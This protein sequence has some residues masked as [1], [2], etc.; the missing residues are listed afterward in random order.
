MTT[1]SATPSRQASWLELFFDLV[2]VA[3]IAQLALLLREHADW[4]HIGIF[5]IVYF[6]VWSTWTSFTFY[7]NV[8][9]DKAHVR[10]MILGMAAMGVMAAAIPHVTDQRT[11]AFIVTYVLARMVTGQI[12]NRKGA[13]VTAWPAAQVGFGVAPWVWSIWTPAPWTYLLWAAGMALD[14]GFSIW[15]GRRPQGMMTQ[16]SLAYAKRAER[17]RRG[18]VEVPQHPYEAAIDAKHLG[19]RIGLFMIIVLGEAIVQVVDVTAEEHWHAYL[20]VAAGA[21]FGIAVCLWL[22]TF[23]YGVLAVPHVSE[24][25]LPTWL[26]LPSHFVMTAV[27]T[28]AAAGTGVLLTEPDAAPGA[29]GRWLLCGGIALFF[30]TAL[31][32]G[33]VL[34]TRLNQLLVGPLVSTLLPLAL[35]LFGGRLPAWA[36][37][38]GALISALWT[39]IWPSLRRVPAPTEAV[40]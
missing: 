13:V 31:V 7:G 25:H 30:G 18:G 11:D 37:L 5:V 8:W 22:L 33:A 24:R 9:G 16:I 35:G 38:V 36:L 34:H 40:A 15:R 10:F 23:R 21:G 27:V 2:A 6:A 19:E 14:I 1:E 3:A 17:R 20:W 26:A 12:W 39:V 29:G 28:V 32:G 4:F